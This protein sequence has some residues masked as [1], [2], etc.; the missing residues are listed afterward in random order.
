MKTIEK[1]MCEDK[2]DGAY[3]RQRMETSYEKSIIN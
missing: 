1:R 2:D 3:V